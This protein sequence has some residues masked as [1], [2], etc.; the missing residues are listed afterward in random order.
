MATQTSSAII[1]TSKRPNAKP[2]IFSAVIASE[3]V[4]R[5]ASKKNRQQ[6]AE[7]AGRYLGGVVVVAASGFL[8]WYHDLKAALALAER[9]FFE[10]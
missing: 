7:L 5:P 3:S 8:I 6:A 2:P 9:T 4:S 1:V 10:V